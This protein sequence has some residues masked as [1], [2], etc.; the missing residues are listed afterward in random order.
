MGVLPEAAALVVVHNGHVVHV[1]RGPSLPEQVRLG[2]GLDGGAGLLDS[3]EPADALGE[4]HDALLADVVLV[5]VPDHV[6]VEA[7]IVVLSWTDADG[8]LVASRVVVRVGVNAQATVVEYQASA[9][10]SSLVLPVVDLRAGD[11]ANVKYLTV[12]DVG[13]RLWQVAEQRI[14]VGRDA[15]AH[16]S[17][18]AL[19]GDYARVRTVADLSGHAGTADLTAVYFGDGTQ[20]HDFRTMQDHI[21]VRSTSHLLFKGAVKGD[22]HGVYT[23][24]IKVR[25]GAKQA[26][27][28]LANRNLVLSETARVDSVPNLEIVNE[29]DLRNCGHASATGPIDDE[30]RFYLESRGVPTD[31]AERLIVLG[32]FDDV[33]A[34]TPVPELRPL[35][36]QAVAV[37][38]D[39]RLAEVPA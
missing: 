4:L 1:D 31:V 10:V 7:P 15:N 33:I 30:S 29:N 16:S 35:L 36:R 3:F 13:R 27:A 19:G 18:V 34:R 32:F 11:A 12:Q 14:T 5:D 21:A 37:K 28:F 39:E 25:P 17:I 22:A 8:A 9:D 24:W 23:G 20:M 2:S 38:L 6:V 26:D